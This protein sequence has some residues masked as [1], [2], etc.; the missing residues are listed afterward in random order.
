MTSPLRFLIL[1]AVILSQTLFYSCNRNEGEEQSEQKSFKDFEWPD[2]KKAAICLTY[3]DGMQT[4][5]DNAIPQLDS[6]NLPGTFYLNAVQAR[7]MVAGWKNVS[8]TGHHELANHTLFHPCPSDMG[9]QKEV[10]TD[11]YTKDKILTEIAGMNTLLAA[12]DGEEGQRSFAFPCN[13]T[14]VGGESYL[15][16]LE[17]SGLISFAR[18]GGDS[19]SSIITNMENIAPFHVPSWPVP[20]GS[21]D[22]IL[23]EHGEQILKNKAFGIFQFH[24]VG[25]QWIS[26]SD[27]THVEFL[28][29]LKAHEEEIWIGTF[30]EIMT[31]IQKY[32]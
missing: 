14:A 21:S 17:K 3:D 28:T 4:H 26:I 2:K 30:S 1:V 31:H 6:F 8:E 12:I 29:W 19:T 10:A 24:G 27:S 9:W 11:F 7:D 23:I 18:G 5:L 22:A 25:G 15:E 32:K 13:N 16:D 20:E